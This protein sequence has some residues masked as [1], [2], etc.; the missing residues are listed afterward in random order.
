MTVSIA[1]IGGGVSGIRAALTLARAGQQVVLFEKNRHLGGRAF[2]FNTPDFGEIDIGQHIWLKCCTALET[3]IRD[4]G[5]ADD[6]VFRQSRFELPYRLLGGRTFVLRSIPWLGPLHLLPDVLRFPGLGL[7][8]LL[9]LGL[10]MARA[11]LLFSDRLEAL[12]AETFASWLHRHNQTPAAIAKLWEPIVLGVCNGRA[13]EVSARH[14]LFTFRESLLGSQHSADI[15]FFRRPLSAI[16]DRLARQTLQAAG[17]KIHTGNAVSHVAPGSRVTVRLSGEVQTFDRVILTL[18][19]QRQRLLLTDIALPEATG[20]G[21]IAGLLLK[22]AR[23]VMDGLFFLGLDSP[24]Q[25][26]FNKTAIWERSGEEEAQVI[27]LVFSGASREAK[28]G[29]D[30]VAAEY[31]PELAKLLPAVAATP[32]L[33]RRLLLHGTATFA[34]PPGAETAR[35]SAT[36]A[37]CPNVF[38]A[39]DEA[40]TGWPSTMESAARAGEAAARAALGKRPTPIRFPPRQPS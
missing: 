12:D 36:L 8:D 19:R 2:S 30:A 17:A 40:A 1:V 24:V 35:L 21:A 22:F 27:E 20:T 15:C 13:A 16:F 6:H 9:H 29:V 11:R 14:A 38:F 5:V 4:L 37:G 26:V 3:L 25:I 33:A 28:M 39:G 32:L 31:L 7:R 23:P 18:P 34:V 10:G